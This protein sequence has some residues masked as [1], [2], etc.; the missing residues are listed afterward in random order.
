MKGAFLQKKNIPIGALI[1]LLAVLNDGKPFSAASAP[2]PDQGHFGLS[3]MRERAHRAKL[4]IE[5][6]SWRGYQGVRLERKTK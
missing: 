2:G 4:E 1:A 5:F 3:N 6:G